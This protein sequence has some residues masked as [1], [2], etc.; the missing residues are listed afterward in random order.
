MTRSRS[1]RG[2]AGV[3]CV[4]WLV[5]LVFV[6]YCLYQIVPVKIRKSELHDF[7]EEEAGFGSIKGI[8]QLEK[9]ILAK[10]RELNLPVTKDNLTV[11]RSREE[12]T[13]E[14]HYQLK[15]VFFGGVYTYVWNVDEVIS[16]PTF[17]V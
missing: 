3:G 16:R 15:I 12:V 5:I 6:G 10:A 1:S 4:V 11:R 9:E 8:Q 14:T 7:M 2:A 17:A 13:V